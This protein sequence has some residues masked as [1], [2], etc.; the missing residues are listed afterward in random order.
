MESGCVVRAERKSGAVL[1]WGGIRWHGPRCPRQTKSFLAPR[2][3][4]R[5]TKRQS[6]IHRQYPSQNA[7][8]NE[9]PISGDALLPASGRTAA[10][11]TCSSSRRYHPWRSFIVWLLLAR[12][13]SI[14]PAPLGIAWAAVK[15]RKSIFD[16][17]ATW[18][19]AIHRL[20]SG[21]RSITDRTDGRSACRH[22]RIFCDHVIPPD[23]LV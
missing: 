18:R 10:P 4:K 22:M 1:F 6:R 5:R 9:P 3:P 15:L 17:R 16:R 20:W 2:P 13:R 21:R 8:A 12:P 23:L 11:L 7:I 19:L 14:G